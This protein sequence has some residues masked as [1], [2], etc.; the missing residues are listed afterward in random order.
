MDR[1]ARGDRQRLARRRILRTEA[2]IRHAGLVKRC[3]IIH[4]VVCIERV[5]SLSLL[6]AF[7]HGLIPG[8]LILLGRGLPCEG[9]DR[10]PCHDRDETSS[11]ACHDFISFRTAG[12]IRLV[13]PAG[14]QPIGNDDAPINSQNSCMPMQNVTSWVQSVRDG[15]LG[16]APTA[17]HNSQGAPGMTKLPPIIHIV[18]DDAS[19][20]C[21]SAARSTN[22]SPLRG[23]QRARPAS[24]R[25]Q[26]GHR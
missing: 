18:D 2:G 25:V 21:W 14:L 22:R 3:S 17:R 1:G 4:L 8:P 19:S 26:I 10:K 7:C 13:P 16:L 23:Q 15:L 6:D 9:R 24:M 5:L 11:H 20:R 12:G